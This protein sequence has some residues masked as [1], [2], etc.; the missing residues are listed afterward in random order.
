MLRKVRGNN[1]IV[2]LYELIKK[3]IFIWGHSNS[4]CLWRGGGQKCLPGTNAIN[5]SGLLV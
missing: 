2:D 3:Y 1:A 5:I 4:V